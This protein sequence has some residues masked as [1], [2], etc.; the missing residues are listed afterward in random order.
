M[1]HSQSN[2]SLSKACQCSSYS[3]SLTRK[4]EILTLSYLCNNAEGQSNGAIAEALFLSE[5][6]IKAHLRGIMTKFEVSDRVQV[7]V[8]ALRSGLVQ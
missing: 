4:E 3:L 7:A 5:S 2:D 8:V 1:R 6:P